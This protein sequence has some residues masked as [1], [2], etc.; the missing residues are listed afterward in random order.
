M[1]KV[2]AKRVAPNFSMERANLKA[3]ECFAPDLR[4]PQAAEGI[5]PAGVVKPLV[6][7]PRPDR[8]SPRARWLGGPG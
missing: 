8:R 2:A 6:R 7:S 1:G 3:W 5:L 4:R